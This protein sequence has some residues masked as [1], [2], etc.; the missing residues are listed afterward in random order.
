MQAQQNR[1][2]CHSCGGVSRAAA[3]G[4]FYCEICGATMP[5]AEDHQRISTPQMAMFYQENDPTTCTNC[6][7]RAGF[8]NGLCLRCGVAGNAP[9][10]RQKS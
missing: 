6:G 8:H 2:Y 4:G 5:F 9:A 10:K 7:A 3:A 1:V